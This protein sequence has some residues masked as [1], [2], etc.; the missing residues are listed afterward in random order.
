M[1]GDCG[2]DEEDRAETNCVE[3]RGKEKQRGRERGEKEGGGERKRP[4]TNK[5]K[6]GVNWLKARIGNTP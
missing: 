6:Q 4:P 3:R 1:W 5:E 2:G